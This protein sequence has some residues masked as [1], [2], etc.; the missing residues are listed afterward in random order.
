MPVQTL[1][2]ADPMPN[3]TRDSLQNIFRDVFD[4]EQLQLRDELS[5]ETLPAWDSLGHI[6]LISALE[7]EL[8]LSF[9]LDE[10]EAM[11][12]VAKILAVLA[13]KT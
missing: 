11:S 1:A 7:D 4:D 9:T 10:I 13:D 12:S 3:N 5:P 8:Q 2:T 6:R